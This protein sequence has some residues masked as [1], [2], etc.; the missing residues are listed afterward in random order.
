MKTTVVLTSQI[1]SRSR[2][3]NSRCWSIRRE[4]NTA[5]YHDNP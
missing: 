5:K 2:Q 3:I 4:L 1:Q